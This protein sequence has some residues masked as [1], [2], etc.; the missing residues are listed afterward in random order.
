MTPEDLKSTL[1][2]MGFPHHKIAMCIDAG[3]TDMEVAVNMIVEADDAGVGG[4]GVGGGGSGPALPPPVPPSSPPT[5]VAL[6][7][8]GPRR[9]QSAT[10]SGAVAVAG[11]ADR[12]AL[13]AT[14]LVHLGD[15]TSAASTGLA[16]EDADLARA[17]EMSRAEVQ[18][19]HSSDT[20]G[21]GGI[22][23]DTQLAIEASIREA[24]A[25]SGG[26]GGAGVGPMGDP[27]SRRRASESVPVGLRNIGNTCYLNSLLQTYFYLPRFRQAVF[28]F[29]S[30]S[31]KEAV[32]VAGGGVGGGG[33]G[34]GGR[35]GGGPPLGPAVTASNDGGRDVAT[36]PLLP[37]SAAMA[38]PTP[39]T[40]DVGTIV[41][42]GDG[43]TDKEN[44]APGGTPGPAAAAAAERAAVEFM[45]HLQS[46]FGTMALSEE[47]VAD[48]SAAVGA[49]RHSDGR[50]LEIGEQQDVSEFNQI[51]LDNVE[52]GLTAVAR[53]SR[54]SLSPV[55]DVRMEGE[56]KAT[57]TSPGTAAAAPAAGAV[58]DSPSGSGTGTGVGGE[59]PNL[60]HAL[61]AAHFEQEVRRVDGGDALS[62]AGTVDPSAAGGPPPAGGDAGGGSTG[63]GSPIIVANREQTMNS[64]I[65]DATNPASRDLHSAL[66]DYVHTVIEYSMDP[67]ATGAGTASSATGAASSTAGAVAG[68]GVGTGVATAAPRPASSRPVTASDNG[69]PTAS[70]SVAGA[71]VATPSGGHAV[72]PSGGGVVVDSP[73][74][75]TTIAMSP[76][77]SLQHPTSP[78]LL[79]GAGGGG[80]GGSGRGDAPSS[81]EPAPTVKDVLFTRFAPVLTIY[82]QR[83][84]FNR[85]V[86]AA[87]KVHTRFDFPPVLAVDRYLKRHAAAASA[88]R[89]AARAARRRRAAADAAAADLVHYPRRHKPAVAPI[90]A[91]LL[92]GAAVTAG[93]GRGERSAESWV[94]P[95]SLPSVAD[96]PLGAPTP[97][98]VPA[99]SGGST[100]GVNGSTAADIAAASRVLSTVAAA[101]AAARASLA[102]DSAGAAAEELAAHAGLSSEEY[103]LHAVLV[104]E[105]SADSGH[106]IAFIRTKFGSGP[107]EQ[108]ASPPEGA[109]AA[110]SVRRRGDAARVG[111]ASC[112]ENKTATPAVDVAA[113]AVA[114][115]GVNVTRVGASAG[116]PGASGDT[117]AAGDGSPWTKFS[118]TAVADVSEREVWEAALGG[119]RF[120]SAYALIYVRADSATTG[121]GQSRTAAAAASGDGRCAAATSGSSG[122]NS[123]T[124]PARDTDDKRAALAVDASPVGGAAPVAGDGRGVPPSPSISAP[125]PDGIHVMEVEESSIADEGRRL[126]PQATLNAIVSANAT[127]RAEVARAV[128]ADQ[129]EQR[130]KQAHRLLEV[131]SQLVQAAMSPAANVLDPIIGTP[132]RLGTLIGFCVGLESLD[133][134]LLRSLEEAWMATVR[135]LP[136]PSD[137]MSAAALDAAIG[138][139]PFS[140]V[141][142]ASRR[143]EAAEFPP[144]GGGGTTAM[145]GVAGEDGGGPIDQETESHRLLEAFSRLVVADGPRK[146]GVASDLA[147][148]VG[149]GLLSSVAMAGL[150][151]RLKRAR[152]LRALALRGVGLTTNGIRAVLAGNWEYALYTLVG[153]LLGVYIPPHAEV[154]SASGD[155][156]LADLYA[157][158]AYDDVVHQFR[159]DPLLAFA[160]QD[161][162]VRRVL[163]VAL[164]ATS[165]RCIQVLHL[166]DLQRGIRVGHLAADTALPVG[167]ALTVRE[168][169]RI[170]AAAYNGFKAALGLDGP[171]GSA[172]DAVAPPVPVP[173]RDTAEAATAGAGAAPAA[174][175]GTVGSHRFSPAATGSAVG[176]V[177]ADGGPPVLPLGATDAPATAATRAVAAPLPP[178]AAGAAT[179]DDA[180]AA[181]LTRKRDFLAA[182]RQLVDKFDT[183]GVASSHRP[184]QSRLLPVD[185]AALDASTRAPAASLAEYV[186]A[187]SHVMRFWAL[188]VDGA[189]EMH[190]ESLRRAGEAL[191][192]HT[193][194]D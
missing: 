25:G 69:T 67:A 5:R 192:H 93:D 149:T 2:G 126:L 189:N 74:G 139:D 127:F 88:A 101:D 109:A 83:V 177:A 34:G 68:V 45:E 179:E 186:A 87:E 77:S 14:S 146:L 113:T 118:D 108:V 124:A 135:G 120:A 148:A 182:V 123:T 166:N 3:I 136:L 142:V 94:T 76:S 85:T 167:D 91:A 81:V 78:R 22:D 23:K 140:L 32:R 170:W 15:A 100:T 37:T 18:P 48:P 70:A 54:L 27:R 62:G 181:L 36:S 188:A 4:I 82:L 98:P 9:P 176:A 151:D 47:A 60:V 51:F 141:R 61:F 65:V 102:A 33:G 132:P 174:T 10:S 112:G 163:P 129:A 11:S 20:G 161:E 53:A 115:A 57:A 137:D 13:A 1:L 191:W 90:P 40:A 156:A 35:S 162:I 106:Y 75:S 183:P 194:A 169:H 52:R 96:P 131:A 110:A 147:A 50:P 185:V 19:H 41:I 24:G 111:D 12:D 144:L 55:R 145:G 165:H 116:T 16:E 155:T 158:R 86:N 138:A 73:P 38:S 193:Q 39:A 79:A 157:V 134:A 6:T 172:T 7:P 168:L 190:A 84:S 97:L 187:R 95:A 71:P 164:V 99:P 107:G 43:E 21:A 42:D 175:A 46:L 103:R 121:E 30:T 104:H 154:A 49:L 171:P 56:E 153:V 63:G 92:A 72:A 150:V 184:P 133:L 152:A 44:A 125:L 26:A 29:R 117:P 178:P 160:K 159:T 128:A 80:D 180:A 31:Y 119:L 89:V 28:S 105:G 59:E 64:I 8:G 173:P 17:M 66:D 130:L 58:P 122:F 143:N 114:G